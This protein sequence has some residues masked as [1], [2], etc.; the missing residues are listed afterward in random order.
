MKTCSKCNI[1]KELDNFHFRND[2]NKHQA[3]CKDCNKKRD[4]LYNIKVGKNKFIKKNKIELFN[5][6]LRKC[7][8]CNIIKDLIYFNNQNDKKDGKQ[9]SCKECQKI[10]RK[11]NYLIIKQ[12]QKI[13]YNNN[14]EII[15]KKNNQYAKNNS[16]LLNK[17]LKERK[18]KDPIFKFKI[19]IRNSINVAFKRGNNQFKK[20]A[21]TE[22]IL[23]C[24]IE[25][26]IIYIQSQ[27]KKGMNFDNHGKWHLDHIIPLATAKTE[28]DVIKLCHYTNYQPLW[29]KD[30]LSKGDKIIEKQLVLL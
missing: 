4:K 28:E 12:R 21:R 18:Q 14:R 20:N 8:K 9:S 1:E 25:E 22:I 2:R 3:H 29:A 27:F 26:F 13:Y 23:G 5:K 24:T 15:I 30:N 7:S 17:K 6:G 10:K 16:V 19:A 11:E